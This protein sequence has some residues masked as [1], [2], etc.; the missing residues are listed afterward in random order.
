MPMDKRWEGLREN[1][2]RVVG[3][4]EV[5]ETNERVVNLLQHEMDLL[6]A[7]LHP[8]ALTAVVGRECDHRGV[9]S[10][11][12]G[13]FAL[14]LI[15]EL[16]HVAKPNDGLGSFDS[17]PELGF[18]GGHG[19]RAL[20]LRCAHELSIVLAECEANARVRFAVRVNTICS[21]CPC[22]ESY[23]FVRLCRCRLESDA[24]VASEFE[25]TNHPLRSR[26]VLIGALR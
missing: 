14:W 26:I 15:E 1:V 25:I 21:V 4:A 16:Q 20:L 10:K 19:D 23:R 5:G 18:A 24:E 9:V 22:D 11:E 2:G 13:W 17:T 8:L 3:C 6:H 12:S 7:V